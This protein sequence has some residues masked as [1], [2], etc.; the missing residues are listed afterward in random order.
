[1]TRRVRITP[2][3]RRD[4]V[5]IAAY[6]AKTWGRAKRDAFMADLDARLR[7]LA[8]HPLLGRVRDDIDP[9]YRSFPHGAHV[10][11]YIVRADAI[12]VIGVPHRARDLDLFFDP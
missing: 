10:I 11:F 9:A 2:R 6:T 3:A 5:D 4:L 8:E 1:M 7:W 12:D